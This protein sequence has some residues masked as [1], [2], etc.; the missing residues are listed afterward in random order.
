MLEVFLLLV[1]AWLSH[2]SGV[3]WTRGRVGPRSRWPRYRYKGSKNPPVVGE[4]R[5]PAKNA[6][7]PPTYRSKKG[8]F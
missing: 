6:R 2:L 8:L 7:K 3:P 5:F 1:V 4:K